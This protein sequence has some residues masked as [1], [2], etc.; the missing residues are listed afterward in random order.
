MNRLQWTF[1]LLDRVTAPAR[2]MGQALKATDAALKKVA[3]GSEAAQ[4]ALQRSF[5]LSERAAVRLT[6]AI[7]TVGQ[8]QGAIGGLQSRVGNLQQ[9]F[10]GV[11][12]SVF[13]LRNALLAGT[14]GFA[15]KSVIDQVGFVEQQRIALG[16]ILGSPIRAKAALS[17]AIQFADQ[18]PFETP[19][20]LEAMRSALAMGFNTK[21]IQPLLTTLGDTASALSLGPSGLNDLIGVFGQIRSA[22][23]L[24]TQ[25]VYQLTNRGI[26]AFEILAKAFNTDIPTVRQ[27]IE[28]G[29]IAS[30][31]ALGAIY[32]GL[33]TR[34]G[35][36]MAAQ[37]RSIFGLISTLRSRS[38]TIA[39]RLEE[40]GALEPFRRV[41]S[42]LADLTDFNKPPGSTIGERL[43]AGI[44][45]LF[46]AAFGPLA[47]AT[48]PKRAGDAILAFINRATATV[49]RARDAWPTIKEAALNF[50]SGVRSGFDLLAGIWR[51]VEPLISGLSRL[52][53]S[54]TGAQ[55][56]MGGANV[57]AVKIIGTIAALTAAWRVLNLVTLGGAGAIARWGAVAVVSL[58]RAAAVGLPSLWAQVGALTT[59]RVT[60]L[61]ASV[62]A[63]LA[64]T[65]MAAAWL[66]GLGPI[67]WLIGGIAAISTALV[68]AY[69][70]VGWFR[71]LVNRAWEGIKQTGKGLLDWFTS[72]PERIG[73]AFGQ[74]PNLLRGLLRRAIDLLPPG[75]RDVVRG[76]VGGLLDGSEPVENAAIQLADKTQQGFSRPLEIRSP[77]RR[78][79]YFGQMMG[80]GLEVG[81]RGSLG[82]VQRAAAGM[83]I[84][85]TLAL[86]GNPAV[87][88]AQPLPT[89]GLPP[90]IAPAPR[91]SGKTINIT[92]G[93]IAINGG[94]D[95]KQIAEELRTVAV[96]AVLEALERAASEE[97]A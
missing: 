78:F 37:S 58:L 23:K 36:G 79:A 7:A 28:K 87:S 50:I 12:D 61:R 91:A 33:K 49:N 32:S 63:L 55:D 9:A 53:D 92:V 56:G 26:P 82:R 35:G 16:T 74:L 67:G 24:M 60:A 66:L 41:L 75:V 76:L 27:M 71:N 54:F 70:K 17:W 8:V 89:P 2:R 44:G 48:E 13:N 97:G 19:Q 4:K 43:T 5:G 6:A 14:I 84:A 81:M 47:T 22:G 62:Q 69:N 95:T 18:T 72:L 64:G 88:V 25:D 86:G 10:R 52:A 11:A 59:L 77:S 83:T 73:Q 42:N 38:Q 90:L 21:Q 45:G 39:F 46:K 29:Q 20:V 1:D 65:R 15:A 40:R 96:E 68:L 93:P 85:A 3:G 30:E 80:A 31:A 51:T 57:N 34:F 94:S